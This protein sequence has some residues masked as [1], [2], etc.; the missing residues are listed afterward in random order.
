[1]NVIWHC[2]E[3]RSRNHPPE[4]MFLLSTPRGKV[5]FRDMRV[6]WHH[7]GNAK[8]CIRQFSQ[9]SSPM[10]LYHKFSPQTNFAANV[11]S[12]QLSAHNGWVHNPQ[13]KKIS[14]SCNSFWINSNSTFNYW[15]GDLAHGSLQ[16]ADNYYIFAC[17]HNM[18]QSVTASRT[19]NIDDKTHQLFCT[20]FWTKSHRMSN[21]DEISWELTTH[22]MDGAIIQVTSWLE[23]TDFCVCLFYYCHVS[24]VKGCISCTPCSKDV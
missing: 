2:E 19:N 22:N 9:A 7:E 21:S 10:S 1:M 5:P 16:V 6:S 20:R 11:N 14:S 8:R 18:V 15:C 24:Q 17:L 4:L 23:N 13:V 3:I 12:K